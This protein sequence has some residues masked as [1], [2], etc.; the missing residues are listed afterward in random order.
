MRIYTL[1]SQEEKI[2]LS[3][4]MNLSKEIPL[5]LKENLI[6]NL[7][8][9]V[10]EE[11]FIKGCISIRVLI[12]WSKGSRLCWLKDFTLHASS[13]PPGMDVTKDLELLNQRLCFQ[14]D[15]LK[16]VFKD[17]DIDY[18][19]K[20]DHIIFENHT[21]EDSFNLIE[22]KLFGKEFTKNVGPIVLECIGFQDEDKSYWIK[23][24]K[25]DSRSIP[26]GVD[27]RFDLDRVNRR[28]NLQNNVLKE[29]LSKDS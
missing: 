16:L 27:I 9:G 1:T 7:L 29:L 3:T 18:L 6:R 11:I 25:V 14:K 23:D 12:D 19:R 17:E 5:V 21:S 22:A 8:F 10:V 26:D 24:F 15:L 20:I 28:R 13:I 2:L 4:L